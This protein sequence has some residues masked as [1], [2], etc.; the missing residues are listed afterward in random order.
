MKVLIGASE[1][2]PYSKTGGLADV[3]SALARSLAR[4]GI[5][6]GVVTPLYR[7]LGPEQGPVAS[8][9]RT[10]VARMGGEEAGCRVVECRPGE[11]LSVYYL[12]HDGFYRRE[13]LYGERGA[14]YPDNARRFLLL[15]R[16]AVELA[17]SLDWRPDILHL[18]DWQAA[19]AA[20]MLKA[21]QWRWADPPRVLLT[22]HN[23]AYQGIF[24][25]EE[26]PLTGL[27]AEYFSMEGAEYHGRI[28]FLKAGLAFA[29]AISTV[30]PTYAR[31]ILG[32]QLGCGLDGLL[33]RRRSR[34]SGILNGADYQEWRTEG[35]PHLAHPYSIRD[36]EGK[37]LEKR[38][39]QRDLSL[40]SGGRVPLFGSVS[41]MVEHK[42][43]PILEQALRQALR[44]PIQFVQLGS[45]DPEMEELMR[46]L[47]RDFPDR[48]RVRIGYEPALAHRIG[49]ASDFHLM[50]SRFEPCGLNQIYGLRYGAIP[51][52]RQTGGLRDTV[53][54][55]GESPGEATG[56]KFDEYSSAALLEAIYRARSVYR[57]PASLEAYR[58]RGMSRDFSWEA[59][60]ERYLELYRSM[61]AR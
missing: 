43:M 28:N 56:I 2:A 7:D 10:L 40:E 47:E 30:S 11:N 1:L 45:G 36:M 5:R 46:G 25:P 34:L 17:R 9:D 58:R 15:S 48:A 52:V 35:N 24:P 39:L 53:A 60:A 61:L 12:E 22:I 31:E 6:T 33:R 20:A 49:A 3:V 4:I 59:A 57:N 51:V 50:P 55:Q 37:A 16:A 26:W 13:G 23:L 21:E 42:G 32:P 29:D 27:P 38:R 41:R 19:M 8:R 44:H 14:D 18:H 54:D